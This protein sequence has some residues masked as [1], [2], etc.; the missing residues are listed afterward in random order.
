MSKASVSDHLIP[1]FLGW[2]LLV[3]ILAFRAGFKRGRR[4]FDPPSTADHS[5]I[6]EQGLRARFF[7]RKESYFKVSPDPGVEVRF[8]K[9]GYRVRVEKVREHRYFAEKRLGRA[10]TPDEVVHHVNGKRSDNQLENLCVL[11]RMKHEQ[12]HAWL[13][14]KKDKQG[15]YPPESVLREVLVKEYGGILLGHAQGAGR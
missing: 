10:L 12:F 13:R 1:A 14:W 6:W 9:Q 3:F 7:V 15:F 8:D 2:S 4:K 11:N 5:P